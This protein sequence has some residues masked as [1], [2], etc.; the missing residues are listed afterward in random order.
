MAWIDL[1]AER[2]PKQLPP[3]MEPPKGANDWFRIDNSTDDPD[4]TDVY[5]YGSIGGF[6]GIYADEFIEELR[7]VTT[8]KISLRLNSGGGSVFEGVA[9]ANAIRAHPANF[10][11]Y[12]DS[13]AASIASVIM[14]AGDRVVMMPQSQVMCHNASGACFGEASDMTKMAD[15]LD[16]QTHN[17]ADAYSQR[18]GRPVSEWLDLMAEESWFSAQEAVEIG[19]A[20]EIYMPPKKEEAEEAVL[21]PAA[22]LMN[23]AWDLSM[24]RYAG[25]DNAPDPLSAKHSEPAQ[26][27]A[28]E[29]GQNQV[30]GE[31]FA[32]FA[33]YTE[34]LTN[35]VR[36]AIHDE[37]IDVFGSI[38]P[39]HSTSVEDGTWDAGANEKRLP[40][41]VPL[42]TVKKMY[43]YWDE[44]QVE[45]GAVPKTACKLPHHFVSEDGT[46]GA[47]SV[48][49]VRNALARLPQ[50]QGLSDAERSAAE[51]HLRKH[52][53]AFKGGE[54]D[55]AHAH[56]GDSVE[57]HQHGEYAPKFTV[58][59]RVRITVDPHEEGQD[60]GVIAE[61]NDGPAYGIRFG[62]DAE[63]GDEIH[64][65]YVEDE[66]EAASE[67]NS[68]D[69]TATTN[70][71]DDWN[72]VVA[73][74]VTPTSPSADDVFAQMKEAWL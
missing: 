9:V 49:G 55:H 72:S 43:T 35:L 40:S 66:L 14:L 73:F 5:V 38:S 41:P 24:Y 64:H 68:P 44:E 56:D 6:W 51:S 37:L 57:A 70:E 4:S 30:P 62:D 29:T 33:Q 10:T 59:D 45:N 25:R 16:R 27:P 12:V 53:A 26:D 36:A 74:L 15:L 47:A 13:L 17:I 18:T 65:W 22:S 7:Q 50:T 63:H 2:R 42:A 19:L 1:V 31:G 61:I 69:E 28:P 20:D 48:S 46:P 21:T 3:G 58:G 54:E 23:R 34:Q 8:P 67:E 71:G 32:V 60:S 52:L 39:S 11:V